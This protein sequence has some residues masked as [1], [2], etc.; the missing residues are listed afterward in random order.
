MLNGESPSAL[1]S[2]GMLLLLILMP[3]LLMPSQGRPAAIC[4]S[5][6][7]LVGESAAGGSAAAA[8]AV[9]ARVLD[10]G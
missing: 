10:A 8:A 4:G 3:S 6:K 5:M 1:S 2:Y 9:V 7:L